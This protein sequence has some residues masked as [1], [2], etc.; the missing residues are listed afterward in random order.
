[1]QEAIISE[2]LDK[3]TIPTAVEEH[4]QSLDAD[5]TQDEI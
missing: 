5:I 3:I 4:V 2:V 1:M